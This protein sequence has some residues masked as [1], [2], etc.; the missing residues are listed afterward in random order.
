[1]TT[2]V[3]EPR[4][5]QP[6]DPSSSYIRD[7]IRVSVSGMDVSGRSGERLRRHAVDVA[8]SP[9]YRDLDRTDGSGGQFVP[10]AWLMNQWIKL[11]QPGR[12][13]AD[14]VQQQAL[15]QA[16]DPVRIP[17]IVTGTATAVQTADNQPVQET[18]L[19]DDF[20][21]ADVK[22]IAGQ[23]SLSVQLIDQ[24]P[25]AMDSVIFSDLVADHSVQ[26]DLQCLVGT[27][28][29]EQVLSIHST[30]NIQTVPVAGQTMLNLYSAV[31]NAIQKIHTSRFLPPQVIV[32]HPQR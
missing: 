10:P 23:Q 6:G 22:T 7:L 28:N 5:Y 19:T 2:H 18:D 3:S 12:P 24:S 8:S 29:N 17:R 14:L 21:Q 25:L 30:P 1:M 26:T 4:T 31:A 11:A 13:F 9:E 15:P 20:V 32:M 16:T 27:G